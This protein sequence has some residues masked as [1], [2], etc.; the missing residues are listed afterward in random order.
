LRHEIAKSAAP[1]VTN[2]DPRSILFLGGL[3]SVSS[4]NLLV[5]SDVHLGSDLVQHARPD[6]PT[7]GRAATR[8]DAELVALLDWYRARR[9][10]E[11]PWRLVIAGDL[12][13]FVGMSMSAPPGEIETQPNDEER[14]HGLGSSVDHT[15]AKLAHVAK[16]HEAVFVALARFVAADNTLV[17]VRGNHD[18]DFH[19]EPVQAAFRAIL[20]RHAP[21]VS[22]HV[23]FADWFY[24]EEGLVYVE[25]GHQYDDYCS[26]EHVL[27]PVLAG[28]P[29]R[30]QRSLSDIL[31]RYVVRPTR[32]MR[33]S[34]HESLSAL[35]YLRFGFRLGNRGLLDLGRRFVVAIAALIS[36]WRNQMSDAGRWAKQE[37]ERKMALLAEARQISIVRLRALASLQRPPV[38][39]SL[40]RLLAGVMIDRVAV[41]VLIAA[42][43]AW[44]LIA[45]WTPLLGLELGATAALFGPLAWLWRRA[46][47]AID[48]SDSLREHA[49]R[50]ARVFPAAF[51]VMGHTHMP[52]MRKSDDSEAVYVNVGAWA[53]EDESEG[54]APA[55][56]ASRTHLVVRSVD[57]QATAALMRWDAEAGPQRFVNV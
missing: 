43:V 9:E 46:R 27:H 6:A 13:D 31:L 41:S 36:I 1:G 26:Y 37:H 38:T 50:I 16:H 18:V 23:E 14:E 56:P 24:Y 19:W 53:E 11:T 7:R 21:G 2:G 39:R 28:D 25:H 12:V 4:H 15:L 10:A 44:L 52:E 35:D 34:G 8:R 49:G 20:D 3:H 54:E 47:G 30:S 40:L 51:V 29:R 55:L 45:R 48:A 22:E 42:V 33:E 17:V 57:G 5:L 32:G